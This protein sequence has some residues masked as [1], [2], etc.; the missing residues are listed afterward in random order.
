MVWYVG[1]VAC[2]YVRMWYVRSV[3][4]VCMLCVVCGLCVCGLCVCAVC[5][6]CKWI[7]GVGC[8]CSEADGEYPGNDEGKNKDFHILWNTFRGADGQRPELQKESEV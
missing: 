7:C 4:M 1:Y 2:V 8:A 6:A 5:V 3:R